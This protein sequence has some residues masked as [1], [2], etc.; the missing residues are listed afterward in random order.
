M[1]EDE[2]L[3]RIDEEEYARQHAVE[4]I[5]LI[6]QHHGLKLKWE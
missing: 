2:V 3:Q 1:I 6:A 4:A 5:D